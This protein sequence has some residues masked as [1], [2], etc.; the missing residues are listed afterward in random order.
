VGNA[1]G[2]GVS[3][4]NTPTVESYRAGLKSI[5]IPSP[6]DELSEMGSDYRVLIETL[7]P[8]TNRLV[9][10]FTRPDDIQTVL[11]GADRPL[12]KYALVEILRRAEFADMDEKIFKTVADNMG[13]QFGATL[14]S[15]MKNAQEDLNRNLKQL[16]PDAAGISLDKPLLLGTLF[17]KKDVC[18][19]GA[20]MP[21]SAKGVTTRMVMEM[22]LLRVQNRLLFLYFYN[23]Y[24]D[25]ST[26]QWVRKTSEQWADA[27]LTANKQ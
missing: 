19:F 9:A 10:A 23:A 11:V 16:N 12:P 14:D 13:S 20:I 27:I 25:E 5:V 21:V 26:A 22:T 8:A 15:G 1:Q 7:V 24:K 17:V 18:S 4:G 3:Q 6:T 2:A